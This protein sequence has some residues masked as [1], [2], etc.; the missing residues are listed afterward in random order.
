MMLIDTTK[1]VF[2]YNM[3]ET[4]WHCLHLVMTMVYHN[5]MQ[6]KF[7]I[8]WSS[9]S[10]C[11]ICISIHLV[12]MTNMFWVLA[13]P[14]WDFPQHSLP[15]SFLI[16]AA[17]MEENHWFNS[18]RSDFEGFGYDDI[19]ECERRLQK[20]FASEGISLTSVLQIKEYY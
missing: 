9:F 8:M 18:D 6:D 5:P 3:Q 2:V 10:V 17:F 7:H 16:F 20:I 13:I 1:R 11:I 4:L 14:K 15:A 12:C 19:R